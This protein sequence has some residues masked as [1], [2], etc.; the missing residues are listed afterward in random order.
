M[1]RTKISVHPSLNLFL[2]DF[3]LVGAICSHSSA[4]RQKHASL[5]N[6]FLKIVA[7]DCALEPIIELNVS[8]EKL[9][10]KKENE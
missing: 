2:P 6:V 7:V 5:G 1:C 9:I 4:L 10:F 3:G 8:F